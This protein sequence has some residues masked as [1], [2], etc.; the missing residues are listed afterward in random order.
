MQ[1]RKENDTAKGFDMTPVVDLHWS[2]DKI[3]LME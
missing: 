2:V 3:N 1:N